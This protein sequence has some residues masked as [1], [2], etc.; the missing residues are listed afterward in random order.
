MRKCLRCGS[1]D[2]QTANCP[3]LPREGSGNLQ[4]TKTNL[5]QSKG[6]GTGSKVP[7]RVYSL[8]QHR[9]P[10]SFENVEGTIPV[11]SHLTKILL[12]LGG[13]KISRTKFL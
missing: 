5:G 3:V 9:V 6:E 8:E 11:F 13:K 4:S 10:D 2:H 7:A 12:D 1:A